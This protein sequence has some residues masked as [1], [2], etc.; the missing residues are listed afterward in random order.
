M[1]G[2]F[3]GFGQGFFDF[4]AELKANNRRDWFEANKPRYRMEVL[5]PLS[6]FVTAMAPRLE[7][8]SAHYVADPRPQGRS[9]FRIYKDMR[10]AKGGTP[11]K[12]HAACQFRHAAGKDAH[13]PGFYVHIAAD[14]LVFGGGVWKPPA[15]ELRRIREAIVAKPG[16]WTKVIRDKQLAAQFGSVSGTGLSRPPRGFDAGHRHIEDLKRQSFFAMRHAAPGL[17]RSADFADEVEA[18]FRAATPLMRF[19]TR[20]VGAPF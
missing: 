12:E 11:Y 10:F 15:L 19:L 9:I 5:A 16:D 4:F 3:P 8:I 6:D 14:E 13:A 20:A 2:A 7:K 1:S 17:A 18:A